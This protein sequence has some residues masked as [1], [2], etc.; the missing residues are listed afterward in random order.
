MRNVKKKRRRREVVKEAERGKRLRVRRVRESVSVCEWKE[1]E[2]E[3]I[4]CVCC[5]GL[6]NEEMWKGRRDKK[7]TGTHRRKGE[8]GGKS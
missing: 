3:E 4:V 7:E 1:E 2:A 8:T 6:D 5:K